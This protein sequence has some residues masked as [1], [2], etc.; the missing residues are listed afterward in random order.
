L[1]NVSATPLSRRG[2]ALVLVG[3]EFLEFLLQPADDRG[4]LVGPIGQ[5]LPDIIDDPAAVPFF[6]GY[7]TLL[8]RP[9][10][11]KV[12]GPL[13][14]QSAE[15]FESLRQAAPPGDDLRRHVQLSLPTVMGSSHPLLQLLF[16]AHFFR[17]RGSF[18]CA[19]LK[20]REERAS[21]V[22]GD[23]TQDQYTQA[24]DAGRHAQVRVHRQLLHQAPENR[25][26]MALLGAT[27]CVT[28][29]EQPTGRAD[30]ALGR[31]EGR[32]GACSAVRTPPAAF[33]NCVISRR[34]GS[35]RG[36]DPWRTA[37][38]CCCR[39]GPGRTSRR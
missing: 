7:P 3:Q 27:V 36:R 2:R 37:R 31:C 13:L 29:T 38:C 39:T 11:G 21:G 25:A 14:I 8:G 30:R 4:R 26:E 28:R 17:Q 23:G 6:L 32:C 5:N 20:G 15:E 12:L 33:T 18:G 10:P 9:G 22:Q 1:T 24:T 16:A 35:C 34:C 19:A